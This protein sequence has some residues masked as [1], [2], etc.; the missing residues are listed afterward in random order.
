M[1]MLKFHSAPQAA[2]LG[3]LNERL[4]RR[5]KQ[6]SEAA[7][8]AAT[9]ATTTTKPQHPPKPN[10]NPKPNARAAARRQQVAGALVRPAL[11]EG[12]A[13]AQTSSVGKQ[14]LGARARA[15]AGELAS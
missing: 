9:K 3:Q 7:T 15:I 13:Q 14:Q 10:W 11:V 12:P 6:T 1:D 2:K 5:R 8:K 4:E